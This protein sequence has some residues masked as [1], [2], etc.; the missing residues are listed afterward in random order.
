MLRSPALVVW[1]QRASSIRRVGGWATTAR[2]AIGNKRYP[3]HPTLSASSVSAS[4]AL[5]CYSQA[6]RGGARTLATSTSRI[7]NDIILHRQRPFWERIG[8]YLRI[9]RLPIIAGGIYSIGYRQG[10]IHSHQHPHQ[11]Q[12]QLLDSILLE[13][14]GNKVER[15]DINVRILTERDVEGAPKK[16]KTD[17]Y[18]QVAS[19]AQQIIREASKHVDAELARAKRSRPDPI[20]GQDER[21]DGGGNGT[22]ARRAA[23]CVR[24]G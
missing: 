1:K 13:A 22:F 9:I 7:L 23:K 21:R 4:A 5:G 3:R 15:Q 17:R 2:I 24:Q 8:S 20:C 11:F 18:F 12:E 16:I 19:V 6:A 10:V 14:T